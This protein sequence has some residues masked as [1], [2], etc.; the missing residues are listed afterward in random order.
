MSSIELEKK[1]LETHVVLCAE[2]YA[3]LEN[4]LDGL[5][6]RM[7]KVEGHLVDIKE[8]LSNANTN[9]YKT[10]VTIGTTILGI[11]ITAVIT[12]IIHL[13]GK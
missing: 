8:S 9:Q 3:V 1:S 7:D 6:T 5:E 13:T 2:R 12:L 11:L 4:K 10:F